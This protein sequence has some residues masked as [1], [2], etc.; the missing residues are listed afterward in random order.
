MFLFITGRNRKIYFTKDNTA[1][2]KSKKNNV[3]VTYM[4]KKTKNGLE[5]K[6][7]Y[8]KTGG[9]IVPN[10]EETEETA[11]LPPT[12]AVFGAPVHP[13]P[14]PAAMSSSARSTRS[15]WSSTRVATPSCIDSSA[16]ACVRVGSG[17]APAAA[18]PG[19]P[20]RSSASPSRPRAARRR[21]VNSPKLAQ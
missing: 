18:A 14:L 15:R 4:F 2:Y 13:V 9:G 12:L 19:T 10:N 3:D 1:F 16:S 8:L 5:L 21:S 6:K 11:T 7:K 17:S 20:R